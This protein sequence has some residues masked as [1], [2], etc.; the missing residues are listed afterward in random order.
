[1]PEATPRMKIAVV[2]PLFAPLLPTQ[3]YGPRAIL[4]DLARALGRRGHEVVV[5]CATGSNV[6]GLALREVPVS[7]IVGRARVDPGPRPP[8]SEPSSA[9]ASTLHHAVAAATCEAFTRVYEAIDHEGAD[10]ITQHAFD[11][12]ALELAGTRPV[13]HTLHLP[14]IVPRVVA[15]AAHV[16]APIATVSRAAR[17][18]WVAAGVPVSLVLRNGVP[19]WEPGSPEVEPVAIIAGRISPE[20]GVAVAIRVALRAGLRPWVVGEP[21]DRDYFESDVVP[22]LGAVRLLPTVTREELW[23]MMARATVTLMPIAWEEP[24]GLVAAEAQM[25]GC[26]VVA[27]RRGALPEVVEEGVGGLLVEPGDEDGLVQAIDAARGLDRGRLMASARRRLGLEAA[28]D[29]YEREL[30]RIATGRD[31]GPVAIGL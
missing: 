10:A 25:A 12:E 14:P 18:D 13:L 11:A 4:V 6:P 2:A 22:L 3:P 20:K 9:G 21:Y 27:Y 8:G 19:T 29:A 17:R 7:P 5:Y 23:R 1:M 31:T 15:A 16:R 28:V 26:P 24:F 30:S